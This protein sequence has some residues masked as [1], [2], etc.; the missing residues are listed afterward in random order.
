MSDLAIEVKGVG[1]TYR[2]WNSPAQRII[3]PLQYIAGNCLPAQSRPRAWLEQKASDSHTDFHALVDINFAVHK[4]ESV[5]IVGRNG[6]GKSTLLQII[7]GT[8]RPTNGS[9]NVQGKVA[10]LL[11]LGSGFNPEFTG[12]ENVFLNAAILGLTRTEIEAKFDR[13]AAFADIGDFLEQPV[14]TYSSGMMMRLAFSVQTAVDPEILIIDEALS[15]GDAQFVAKCIKR[16]SDFIKAGGTLLFV[17]HDIGL[18]RQMTTRALYLDSGKQI[19]FDSTPAV[20]L[21]YSETVSK[22]EG[23]KPQSDPDRFTATDAYWGILACR[24]DPVSEIV[25][26]ALPPGTNAELVVLLGSASVG[27]A[28][29]VYS[30]YNYLGLIV[31]SGAHDLPSAIVAGDRIQ[32]RIEFPHIRLAAG[33]YRINLAVRHDLEIISWARNALH[34]SVGGESTETYI[35]REETVT[36]VDFV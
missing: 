15:V 3:A 26:E 31:F 8:L 5:G 10:A 30:V 1:K 9:A 4:G 22:S 7:A 34:F 28:R 19:A 35:Y 17:S 16:I 25:G 29:L 36:T 11:E 27:P 2:V 13:I 14:K 12:R 32:V 23:A 6:S 24:F 21:A 33:H 18:V 20:A